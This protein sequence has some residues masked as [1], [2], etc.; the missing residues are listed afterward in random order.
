MKYIKLY[1]AFDSQVIT[2]TIKFLTKK[3]GE[4]SATSFS[5]DIKRLMGIYNI[6]ISKIKEDD[7]EYT[8]VSKAI[9]IKNNEPVD[10]N[11]NTYCIKYWFSVEKGYLGKTA[12]GNL[13]TPYVK[14]KND[15]SYKNKNFDE[16]Q[17]YYIKNNLG[18]NKGKLSSVLDYKSLKTGDDVLVVLGDD[19]SGR[20][21][22]GKIFIDTMNSNAIYVY[23]DYK[24]DG[25]S[26]YGERP[27]FADNYNHSWRLGRDDNDY[28]SDGTSVYGER[29]D[30][31][32]N[33]NHSWRLGRDENDDSI[34]HPDGDHFR[35]HLYTKNNR[36]L[37][38]ETKVDKVKHKANLGDFNKPLD[39]YGNIQDWTIHNQ[40][41]IESIEESD[42]AIIVYMSKLL[43]IPSRNIIQSSRRDAR[44]GATAL[45]SN[46]EIK[47]ININN[48]TTKLVAKY[49]LNKDT[50]D[51]S[52]LNKFVNN[53]MCNKFVMFNLYLDNTIGSLN[54]LINQ[55]YSLVNEDDKEHYFN[56]V[57]SVF[58]N[59]RDRTANYSELYR[60]NYNLIL[61]SGDENLITIIKRFLSLGEKINNY[62]ESVDIENIHDIIMVKYKLKAIQGFISDS[63]NKLATPY[64]D[65]I[66]TFDEGGRSMS[67]YIT[68]CDGATDEFE[69]SMEKLD[70]I[71]KFINS[72]LK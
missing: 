63:K 44:Q 64:N 32:D 8:R 38:Q 56:N 42:F 23:N 16:D 55:L 2:N 15:Y 70:I 11:W 25:T 71:E 50:E 49:G 67:R 61:N 37:R 40:G 60:T 6:P 30:F 20:A 65:V 68:Y 7:L 46:N 62:I 27:D 17:L 54:S 39:S 10:N 1:E 13:T 36:Q 24:S 19:N 51:F 31:A 14:I 12:V 72:L 35:L 4:K 21:A 9:K 66:N 22:I 48:Y 41:M 3:I 53:I 18:V 29:P 69:T 59:S 33:Y 58:K 57:L 45:M 28:K 34:F 52:K 43:S 26:V 5:D 47:Q